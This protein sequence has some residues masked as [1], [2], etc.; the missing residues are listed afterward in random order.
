M[1]SCEQVDAFAILTRQGIVLLS[2]DAKVT[3]EEDFYLYRLNQKL[4]QRKEQENEDSNA[5]QKCSDR[6]AKRNMGCI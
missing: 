6:N 3:P 2:D 1:S 4:I 5:R